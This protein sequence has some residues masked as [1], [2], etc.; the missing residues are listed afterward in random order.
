M[1]QQRCG[2]SQRGESRMWTDTS[3]RYKRLHFSPHL[4]AVYLISHQQTVNKKESFTRLFDFVAVTTD[5]MFPTSLAPSAGEFMQ[6]KPCTGLILKLFYGLTMLWLCSQLLILII[7]CALHT[8]FL[9][10]ALC[11]AL[12]SPLKWS[13]SNG[14]MVLHAYQQWEGWCEMTCSACV[15][16]DVLKCDLHCKLVVSEFAGRLHNDLINRVTVLLNVDCG[17]TR[18]RETAQAFPGTFCSPTLLAGK[19]LKIQKMVFDEMFL[20]KSELSSP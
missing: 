13:T 17:T 14:H 6:I 4:A 11:R 18:L 8:V 16:T 1:T 5:S 15:W 12:F 7:L 3:W 2:T 10:L 9:F 20:F 19:S